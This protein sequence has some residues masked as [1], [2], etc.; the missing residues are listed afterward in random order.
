MNTETKTEE[1]RSVG[2]LGELQA[3]DTGNFT[4]NLRFTII[5]MKFFTLPTFF[6]GE[7]TVT[8]TFDNG[9][10]FEFDEKTGHF[11]MTKG[12]FRYDTP[13]GT[14]NDDGKIFMTFVTILHRDS[15][16]G[17][18]QREFDQYTVDMI[19]EPLDTDA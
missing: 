16:D 9:Y 5:T 2:D 11:H 7:V 14:P 17:E 19:I 1:P 12:Y 4:L 15:F 8:H 6:T 10:T 13:N 18:R 3:G